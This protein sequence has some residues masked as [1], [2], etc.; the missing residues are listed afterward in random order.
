M[1]IF[2]FA[3][4][5]LYGL[6]RTVS[7]GELQ[8]IV[9]FFGAIAAAACV[10]TVY[11]T[12]MIYASLKPVR[13]WAN[14]WTPLIYL[15]LSI[16]TGLVLLNAMAFV[17]GFAGAPLAVA[18]AITIAAGLAAKFLYWSHVDGDEDGSTLE[19]ATG[20]GSMG[21]VRLLE[22]PHSEANYLMKEMVF[23]IAR[24]HAAKLRQIAIAL[25]FVAPLV[26]VVIA[27]LVGGGMGVLL[28]LLAVALA[29][30]GIY[31]E[32]WLFFA[33]ARHTVGLYYGA[34]KS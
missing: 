4:A 30:V 15:I 25:G 34:T 16:M 14:G 17:F 21:K 28:A 8:V 19:T 5:G 24:K 23:K 32:R 2:T 10:L 27:W 1:A 29:A 12:A 22:A 18:T 33:E 9:L 11:C 7:G 13:A 3:P 31:V 6:L 26:G 20:L